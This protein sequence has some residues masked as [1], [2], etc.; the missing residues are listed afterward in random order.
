M[1]RQEYLKQVTIGK[2]SEL[3]GHIELKEYDPVWGALYEAERQKIYNALNRDGIVIEHVGSTSVPGLC[4]KPIIDI[5]L[6]VEDSS[7][8][9]SDVPDLE[10]AGSAMRGREPEWSGHRRWKGAE[11]EVNLHVFSTGCGEA[12]RMLDFRDWLRTHEAD[13]NLYAD[14]KRRLVQKKWKYLQDYADAKS[15]VVCEILK[16]M[17]IAKI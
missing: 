17:S 3:S 13:R 6:L 4:A 14:T 15:E 8:E 5:L 2:I 12:R 1:T 10:R 9:G 7:D 16:H 11:P